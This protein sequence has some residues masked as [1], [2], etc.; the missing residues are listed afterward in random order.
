VFVRTLGLLALIAVPAL[1]IFSIVPSLLLRV[2]FGPQY[3]TAAGALVLLGAAMSFL[4][5]AYLAVQYMLALR[6]TA[7]LWV[8]GVVAV[9]E[10]FLLT[11]GDLDL[12]SF[13]TVVFVMQ[14][15]AAAGALALALRS[16]R[17]EP[18]TA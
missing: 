13:A 7:F 8:L 6:K 18:A 14:C 1:I 17:R 11:M 4:A 15:L 12:V 9:A 2:A 5:V 10:P 16:T 3:T